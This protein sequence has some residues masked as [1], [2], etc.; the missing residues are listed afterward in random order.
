ML[1][2]IYTAVALFAWLQTF[3]MV[4]VSF[5]TIQHLRKDLFDKFQSLSLRFFDKLY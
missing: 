1:G 3:M 5:R 2:M 4:R